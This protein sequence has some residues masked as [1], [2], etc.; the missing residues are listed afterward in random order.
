M[1]CVPSQK[2]RT[3]K[4]LI[5]P[6][7]LTLM[8]VLFVGVSSAFAPPVLLPL[9]NADFESPTLS[10]GNNW[11]SPVPGWANSSPA[12][13][14]A[15][16]VGGMPAASSGNQYVWGNQTNF[17]LSQYY[18][19]IDGNARYDMLVDLW[20]IDPSNCSASVKLGDLTAGMFMVQKHYRPSWNT[21]LFQFKLPSNQWSTVKVSFHGDDF[22]GL[23]GH[24][25]VVNIEG[26]FLAVDNVRVYKTVISNAPAAT[27]HVSSSGGNDS[28]D[29]LSPASAW[30]S[31]TNV[32][33]R[34][35]SAGSSILLKRGDVW[36]DE[37]NLRGN[38]T[39]GV[40]NE[41]G[42][43]GSG[44]RPLIVRQDKEFDR[45][46]VL[47]NASH[48]R[49]ADLEGRTAC[50]GLFL[51]Y[52]ESINHTNVTVENCTFSD[53]DSWTIDAAVHNSEWSGP[54]GFWIG[55]IIKN[56]QDQSNV[57]HQVMFRN[58]AA[59]NCTAGFGVNY[60]FPPLNRAWVTG[61]L[62]EDCYSTRVSIGGLTLHGISN[63]TIRR[64]RTFD[65]CGNP[66]AFVW[67]STGGIISSSANVLIEDCEFSETDRMWP[68]QTQGDGCSF[69]IDGNNV[70][71]TVR[72]CVFHDNEGPGFLTLSTYGIANTGVV[73]DGCTFWNNALDASDD[74]YAPGGNAY[75]MKLTENTVFGTVT[76]CGLYRNGLATSWYY[77]PNPGNISI[78]AIRTNWWPDY[79]SRPT[80]PAWEWNTASDF[81]GWTN[82]NQ[83]NSPAVAGGVFTGTASGNDPFVYSPL[84]WV[85][86]HRNSRYVRLRM[87][88]SDGSLGV[89]FF[90]TEADPVWDINK[91]VGFSLIADNQFHDYLIDLRSSG[92]YGGVVTQLRLDPTETPGAQIEIDHLR[93]QPSVM[94]NGLQLLTLDDLGAHLRL[95]TDAGITVRL[96]A[97]TDLT[98]WSSIST[99][100]ADA[101]GSVDF[102]DSSATLAPQRF[103]RVAWP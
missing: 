28:N 24:T 79:S 93:W 22:A 48:W 19:S 65:P 60:Y 90:T 62:I 56:G 55:G 32:N 74:T 94:G 41:L 15:Y 3:A 101:H 51:R 29:G 95:Q 86:T 83:W 67:G 16:P 46:V 103:Y 25:L 14:V 80:H 84:L 71:I 75:E 92:G 20:P 63:S 6:G 7:E 96:Q 57:L 21:N 10:P 76:N 8:A 44:P 26:G 98:I 17:S 5:R 85:N 18:N 49:V 47:N 77:R 73:I 30:R 82:R 39:P 58:C 87:K 34:R 61:L 40:T 99:N 81:E 11:S 53:M 23:N 59:V 43:Y 45:C 2:L 78:P 52:Y 100:T 54:A 33:D 91:A 88:V 89:L 70:N 4:A 38:G 72:R 9:N 66:G 97:S 12:P 13:G 36:Y 69:D 50:L 37:L 31:F 102:T 64:F 1:N 68:D 35:F 42:A 27:Y